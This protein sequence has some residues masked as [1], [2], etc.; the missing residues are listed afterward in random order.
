MP[1]LPEVEALRVFLTNTCVGKDVA[2]AELL[3]FACLKTFETPL[4]ALGGL[5][6]ESVARHGKFISLEIGGLWLTFHLARAGWLTWHEVIQVR[7]PRPG[8]GPA[9]FQLVFADNSGFNLTEA[10]TQKRLA[11][12]L[13]TELGQVAGIASLGPD[14]L[15]EDFSFEALEG[16]LTAAGKSQLKGVLRDQRVLAGIGNAYSDEILHA[17]KLSPFKPANGLSEADRVQLYTAIRTELSR[18]VDRAC[19]LPAKELKASKRAHLRVHGRTGQPCAVCG[20]LIAEVSYAD[21][22]LQYCPG[23]Q[24]EGKMLADRRLSRL[25]K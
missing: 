22:S 17:A 7:T 9:A 20:T 8:N 21:S 18:A 12:Y 24:T 14:P 13:T 1:E 2:R 6:V 16:I 25:L 3:A 10:G 23:C 4:S 15:A 5:E 19:A 11:V